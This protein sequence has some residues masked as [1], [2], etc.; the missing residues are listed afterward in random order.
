PGVRTTAPSDFN[1]QAEVGASFPNPNTKNVI[2]IDDMDGV[3][4]GIALTMSAERW[5]HGSVPS[6]KR[7]GTDWSILRDTLAQQRN[8]EINWFT[9]ISAVKE[10]DLKPNLTPA[11]GSQTTHTSLAI[12]LPRRPRNASPDDTLWAGLTYPLDAQ[13]LGLA[14]PQFIELW[15]NDLRDS[16]ERAQSPNRF[17]KLHVDLGLVS[18]DQMRSPD[19]PPNGKIDT[20]DRSDS[21]VAPDHQLDVSGSRNEDTGYDQRT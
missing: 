11:E 12:S 14:R 5:L 13:G 9:P 4:D 19:V 10:G 15:V 1:I 3:R 8:A 18:E 16:L 20:E 21:L 6:R 7:F 17:M 2:Y